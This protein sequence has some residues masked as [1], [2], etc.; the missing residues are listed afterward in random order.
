MKTR[1]SILEGLINHLNNKR[2][3][4]N[5]K[6]NSHLV[7]HTTINPNPVVK[8]YKE[9]VSTIW[10][11][12]GKF[13]SI[14]LISRVIGKTTEDDDSF[15]AKVNAKLASSIFNWIGSEEYQYVLRGEYDKYKNE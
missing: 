8:L 5:I 7:L 12:D 2:L 1:N 4:L 15:N 9:Y 10:Y 11:I 3:E 6:T 14:L 13:K